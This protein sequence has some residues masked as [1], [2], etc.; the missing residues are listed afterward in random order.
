MGTGGL[1]VFGGQVALS[2]AQI[3]AMN[4][5]QTLTALRHS[6][7]FWNTL[8]LSLMGRLAISKMVMLPST[9]YACQNSLCPLTTRIFKQL[10]MILTSL[11][12]AGRRSRGALY[13]MIRSYEEGGL[14][15]P[16]FDLYYYAA[17]LQ[18]V[19]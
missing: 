16:R 9:L 15:A 5:D 17:Q 12:W 2:D 7:T 11:L 4:V 6:V 1:L 3:V 14:E 8:P 18:H 19:A 13:T 10:N